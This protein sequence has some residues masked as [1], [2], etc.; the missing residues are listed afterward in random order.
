MTTQ[1]QSLKNAAENKAIDGAV[2][3]VTIFRIDPAAII[4]EEGFNAKVQAAGEGFIS[5]VAPGTTG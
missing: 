2:S 5:P 3:K 4:V 1:F